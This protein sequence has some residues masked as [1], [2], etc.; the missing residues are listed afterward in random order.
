MKYS[1]NE[2]IRFSVFVKEKENN[3]N[4]PMRNST[5][6]A[7]Y[8]IENTLFGSKSRRRQV[9]GLKIFHILFNY[10]WEMRPGYTTINIYT[11]QQR[12]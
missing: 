9:Y 8:S 1:Y 6:V 5:V 10:S 12:L 4:K 2:F 7:E 3:Q 11:T